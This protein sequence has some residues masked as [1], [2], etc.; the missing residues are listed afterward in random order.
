LVASG[1]AFG[2]SLR[3]LSSNL[4][5]YFYPTFPLGTLFV[6]IIGSFLIGFLMTY[7]ENK[8][9]SENFIRYFLIVG[10]LGSFTTFSAFS[11]E[12]IDIFNNHKFLISLIYVAFSVLSCLFCAYLGYNINKI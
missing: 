6:N 12:A 10:I 8:N 7:L 3:Y 4:L 2:A 9:I 11:F 5:R 1:G